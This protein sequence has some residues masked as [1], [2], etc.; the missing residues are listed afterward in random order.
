MSFSLFGRPF[1]IP[2]KVSKII[3]MIILAKVSREKREAKRKSYHGLERRV[4]WV[5]ARRQPTENE[6]MQEEEAEITE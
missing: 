6:V 5:M 4:N 2:A 1:L 3:I